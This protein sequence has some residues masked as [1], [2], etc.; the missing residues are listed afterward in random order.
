M[1]IFSKHLC[2]I[3]KRIN[4]HSYFT[5]KIALTFDDG[6]KYAPLILE[7]LEQH[8]EKAT[9]F[10]CGSYMEENIS[11]YQKIFKSGHEIENHSYNHPNMLELSEPEILDELSKT[12]ELIEQVTGDSNLLK[13]FRFPYGRRN[14]EITLLIENHG[15]IP[16]KW[17]IDSRDWTGINAED[18]YN[19]ILKS[20]NLS[21]GAIILMHTSGTH[22]AEALDL[23]IPAL[24]QKGYKL[25]LISDLYQSI[26]RYKKN[27]KKIPANPTNSG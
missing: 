14:K 18:I 27:L 25:M 11:I 8:G 24:K 3:F 13:F 20:N 7:K 1:K 12:Q 22:T 19:N 2:H 15:Y 23:I 9:F 5:K 21:N 26:R 10:L 16:V 6:H 4:H 17:T